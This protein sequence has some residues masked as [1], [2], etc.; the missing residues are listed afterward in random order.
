[1]TIVRGVIES[2]VARY[3]LHVR[4]QRGVVRLHMS[5]I[6]D[7]DV[8]TQVLA[9]LK[10]G[11]G[12]EESLVEWMAELRSSCAVFS[13][14]VSLLT[15]LFAGMA[16]LVSRD[17]YQRCFLVIYGLSYVYIRKPVFE[18]GLRSFRCEELLAFVDYP[19][20]RFQPFTSLGGSF[21]VNFFQMLVFNQFSGE[22]LLNVLRAGFS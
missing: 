16:E 7:A 6:E 19:S 14:P 8:V 5:T 4:A 3:S 11:S 20:G 10:R 9:V 18:C 15:D 17:V 2:S 22:G 1:M 13:S 12:W 21:A